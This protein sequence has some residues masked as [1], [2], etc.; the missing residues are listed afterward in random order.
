MVKRIGLFLSLLYFIIIFANITCVAS[1]IVEYPDDTIELA[2]NIQDP[3][4][5]FEDEQGRSV[6][7][8]SDIRPDDLMEMTF[9]ASNFENRSY[10]IK[11]LKIKYRVNIG[12]TPQ[13]ELWNNL[14]QTLQINFANYF[15]GNQTESEV[16]LNIIF[17]V[18]QSIKIR[19][20]SYSGNISLEIL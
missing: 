8:L 4:N 14:A 16:S 6:I 10:I 2:T 19:R 11:H 3:L 17:V 15:Q 5:S 20:G 13:W 7:R 18:P 12:S 1:E 9:E